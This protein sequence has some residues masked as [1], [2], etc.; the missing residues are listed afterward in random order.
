ME[1]VGLA[2][3]VRLRCLRARDRS[4]DPSWRDSHQIDDRE[5]PDPDYVERVPEQSKAQ[6]AS[7]DGRAKVFDD[8]L[9]HHH[10]QPNQTRRDM[11]PMTSDKGEEGREKSTALRSRPDG[12]HAGELAHLQSKE[13]PTKRK[14]DGSID[15][16]GG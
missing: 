1:L 13:R 10:G 11:K 8:N 3:G 7:H 12:Y 14:S 16:R 2:L 15:V 9:R 4:A 6:Q 5:E